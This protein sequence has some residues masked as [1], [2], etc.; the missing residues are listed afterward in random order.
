[1]SIENIC[2]GSELQ[3]FTSKKGKRMKATTLK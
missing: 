3:K 1:M 2:T